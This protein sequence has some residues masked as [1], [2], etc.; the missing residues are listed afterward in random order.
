MTSRRTTPEVTACVSPRTTTP[1]AEGATNP[2]W[3]TLAT[4]CHFRLPELARS[5]NVSM[6]TLQRHFRKHYDTTLSEWVR[7]LRLEKARE[8]LTE[9]E[10]VKCVAFELGYKQPSHFSRDFKDRF[11]VSPSA[12]R[13]PLP[14]KIQISPANRPQI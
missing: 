5:C 8:M 6:R 13:F 3:E 12:L 4:A 10:S 11:G 2:S 7:E 14:L 1:P 9:A